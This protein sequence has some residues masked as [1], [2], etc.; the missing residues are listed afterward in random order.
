MYIYFTIAQIC[1]VLVIGGMIRHCI[2]V[3][4]YIDATVLCCIDIHIDNSRSPCYNSY[5]NCMF[6][7]GGSID[8]NSSM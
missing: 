1:F 7:L 5:K 4:C 6:L 8:L 2:V 3:L